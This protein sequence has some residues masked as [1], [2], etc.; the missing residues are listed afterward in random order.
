LK[1]ELRPYQQETVQKLKKRLKAV[2]H[3]LLVTA[4]VGSGKSLM[5]A[6]VLLW[7]EQAGYR[8]LCLTLNST[9]IQQN[10]ETYKSQGGTCGIYAASIKSKQT[11]ELIIFGSPQ[12]VCN[13]IRDNNEISKCRFNLIVVDEAH[14][15]D[16]HDRN[17]MFQRIIN[18]YGLLS[19]GLAI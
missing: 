1:K 9:L 5:I 18:H 6:E 2:T 15:I 14:N 10:S 19:S 3:P 16:P 8:A 12:S 17:T 4:S 11:E 13:G 7:M